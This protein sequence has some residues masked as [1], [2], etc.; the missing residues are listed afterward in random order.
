MEPK[1]GSSR[2][3]TQFIS[4]VIF[5]KPLLLVDG[6]RQTRSFTYIDDGVDALLRIIANRDGCASR[7]IFNLGN[8]HNEV[9]VAE[10]ARLILA[11][12]RHYPDYADHVAAARLEPV[13]SQAYFGRHYQDIRKR[14]PSIAAARRHLG[15]VP[16]TDLATAIR[17]TLDFHLAR[18]DYRLDESAAGGGP[19]T[20]PA[21]HQ[22]PDTP[23]PGTLPAGPGRP[24]VARPAL[25]GA[26]RG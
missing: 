24:G 13:D 17:R 26:G 10:L 16:T 14:V 5:R 12:F 7:R 21:S 18:R 9:S 25:A 2:L 19:A 15:W 1:E 20:A 3:F 6:G 23:G 4:N 11:A 8:P 22:N